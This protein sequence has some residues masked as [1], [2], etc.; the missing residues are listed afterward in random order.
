MFRYLKGTFGV[1]LMYQ[2]HEDNAGKQGLQTRIMQDVLTLEDH[3]L[4][5]CSNLEKT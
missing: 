2:K 5:S 1:G 3:L 4:D